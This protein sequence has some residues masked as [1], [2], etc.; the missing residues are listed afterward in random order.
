MR[1]QWNSKLGFLLAAIGSAV[2]LGNIW[3]FPYTAAT[4]G[5]GAFLLPYLFAIISAGIPILILEYTMGKT[6]RGGAPV[7]W[8]R[9]N[10]RFEWLGWFQVMIAFVISVYYFAIVVWV[11]SYIGF[12]FT[13][14]WG[15]DPTNFFF[16]YL[17][18]TEGPL[19]LGGIQTNLIL[20]FVIVWVLA[21]LIMYRGISKGIELACKIC[22]PLLMVLILVLVIRGITLPGAVDGLNFLFT[23]SWTALKDPQVWVAAYGQVF[24]SLSIAFAIMLA[25][26]SYLP[27]K[28]DVVNSAFITATANHGFELLAGIG[29]FSIMGYMAYQQGASVEEV[30]AGGI[31][32]A[33]MTFP[34]AISA[35]PALNGLIG[36]CFFGALFFAGITS[37][38]S[39]L[40]AV[41]SGIEDKFSL[42]HKKAVTLV[43]V[44]SFAISFLFIT[45]AGMYILDIVDAFINNIGI[46]TAGVI[47]VLLITWFFKPEQLRKEANEFS[48]FSIGKWWIYTLKFITII[49]L[50]F[51]VILSSKNYIMEGYGG[52]DQLPVTIFGWGAILLC[53]VGMIVLTA[54]KGKDGYRDLDKISQKEVG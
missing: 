48:N 51:M 52:Y 1:D 44:P 15:S 24:F 35:L 42:K 8:A 9:I 2:G 20:P 16:E 18:L 21:A 28:T 23:P 43:L 22:L 26:S 5:G 50:G 30:A 38:I 10:K 6:Y 33:F 54:L 11:V 47:E 40:Q 45:G 14:A 53:V 39:I 29:V 32:L 4:N 3:R 37:L 7:T 13:Q 12:S 17:G 36:I 19:V 46:V 25:Y 41:I 31:G 49:V 27:R 34:T